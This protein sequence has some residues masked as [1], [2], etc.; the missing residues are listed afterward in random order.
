[1]GAKVL[2]LIRWQIWAQP[3]IIFCSASALSLLLT[4]RHM[5]S[6]TPLCLYVLMSWISFSIC[7]FLL[8]LLLFLL[9]HQVHKIELDCDG[10]RQ[11]RKEKKLD[12]KDLFYCSER[13]Y[14]QPKSGR[15]PQHRWQLAEVCSQARL[16]RN[17]GLLLPPRG[18]KMH[19]R[20]ELCLKAV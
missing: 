4:P 3:D 1:M 12:W 8:Y 16:W 14:Q 11:N 18:W 6:L 9:I 19:H 15:W 5:R 2:S 7:R 17:E 13:I 20:Q 10:W